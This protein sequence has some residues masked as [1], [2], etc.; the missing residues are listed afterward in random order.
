LGLPGEMGV[1]FH[2]AARRT[3][4]QNN[5]LLGRGSALERGRSGGDAPPQSYWGRNFIEKRKIK[6]F[7]KN[8]RKKR[9][10]PSSGQ[11]ERVIY[12]KG[13]LGFVE[14]PSIPIGK[15]VFSTIGGKRKKRGNGKKQLSSGPEKDAWKG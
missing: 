15:G 10:P 13:S 1:S 12:G 7:R 9:L 4:G 8:E 3:P 11:T 14:K 5:E 2:Q 6:P